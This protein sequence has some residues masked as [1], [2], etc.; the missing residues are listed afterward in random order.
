[1][2]KDKSDNLEKEL[3]KLNPEQRIKKL[4]E[5]EKKKKQEIEKAKKLIK[6]SQEELIAT[7]EKEEIKLQKEES[8]I[9]EAKTKKQ[10]TKE[11]ETKETTKSKETNKQSLEETISQEKTKQ[12][13][14]V[15]YSQTPNAL[16]QDPYQAHINQ[17]DNY[18]Q[19]D[20]YQELSHTPTQEIYQKMSTFYDRIKEKGYVNPQEAKEIQEIAS[21]VDDRVNAASKGKYVIDDKLAQSIDAIE[22][23][24]KK[25]KDM[26]EAKP[27]QEYT[28]ME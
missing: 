20:L 10:K 17:Q 22:H 12:I 13:D 26:Y 21:I 16:H 3:K 23:M 24:T 2:S 18:H 1:M 19:Q 7:K 9:K 15:T 11:K 27:H 28:K 5:Q 4:K 6:E 25:A 14:H 8:E